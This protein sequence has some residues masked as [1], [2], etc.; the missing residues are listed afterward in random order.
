MDEVSNLTIATC[1][2]LS[3]SLNTHIYY[4]NVIWGGGKYICG[5]TLVGLILFLM[6]FGSDVLTA[7]IFDSGVLTVMISGFLIH[8]FLD[9]VDFGK[10]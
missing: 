9:I 6:I 8:S 3:H 4:S 7:T 1:R 10:K 2:S 5:G